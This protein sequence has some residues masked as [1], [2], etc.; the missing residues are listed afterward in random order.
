MTDLWNALR[1]TD[2]PVVLYG[3]GN[4]ADKIID[5][6]GSRGIPL[7]GV[8]ASEGFVRDR[9]FRGMMVRGY[10]DVVAEFGEGI[11]ILLAF[12]TTRAEVVGFIRSLDARHELYIP[13]VP[14]YG[15]TL[16]DAEYA[17]N[18]RSQ[19]HHNA[20]VD[21]RS[22]A[23]RENTEPS[24]RTAS[25]H[26]QEA[27]NAVAGEKLLH[28]SLIDAGHRD[29]GSQTKDEKHSQSKENASFKI[30]KFEYVAE[31]ISHSRSPRRFRRRRRSSKQQTC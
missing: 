7:A 23:K 19:L 12:G 31:G 13:E 2:K 25:K 30:R 10:S 28:R 11:V 16:F 20:R 6:C 4:G 1:N 27:D 17:E 22:N 5:V 21:V 18:H 29:L 8:F 15:G 24:Q 26:I 9:F 14:L 3:T